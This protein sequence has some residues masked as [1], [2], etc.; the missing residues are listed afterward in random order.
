MAD[1]KSYEIH[2]TDRSKDPFLISPYTVDGPKHPTNNELDVNAVAAHTSLRLVGKGLPNYGERIFENLVNLLENFANPTEPYYPIEGQIWYDTSDTGVLK[3]YD[4]SS[5]VSLSQTIA[6]YNAPSNPTSGQLWYDSSTPQLMVWNGSNWVSTADRYLLKSGDLMSGTLDMDGNYI[7]NLP[8]LSATDPDHYAAPKGYVDAVASTV[9]G[10]TSDHIDNTSNVNS[11]SGSVTDALNTLNTSLLHLDGTDQMAGSLD[12]GSNRI[13]NMAEPTNAHDATTKQWVEDHV[14]TEIG[15]SEDK[16]LESAAIAD[17]DGDGYGT[18]TLTTTST[19]DPTITVDTEVALESHTHNAT[20]VTYQFT[21]E[22]LDV[23]INRL[24]TD[25]APITSPTFDGNA[26]IISSGTNLVVRNTPTSAD[27]AATKSYVDQAVSDGS[28]G[29]SGGLSL[30]DRNLE[31]STGTTSFTTPEYVVGTNRL[32]VFVNGQKYYASARGTLPILF[33]S[34]VVASNSSELEPDTQGYQTVVLDPSVFQTSENTGLTDDTTT[35][36]AD[37]S[38]NGNAVTVSVEGQNAQTYESLIT[39][40][41]NAVAGTPEITEITT[42]AD[43]SGS[44]NET[45][46]SLNAPSVEVYVWYNVD[47]TGTD[48]QPLGKDVGIEV[49]I[50][51]DDTADTV[52]Q[53]TENILNAADVFQATVNSNVVTITNIQGGPVTNASDGTLGT[54]FSF[55]ITQEGSGGAVASLTQLGNLQITS[56]IDG[57][58]STISINDTDLFSSLTQ[59]STINTAVAGT[60]TTYSADLTIDGSINETISFSGDDAQTFYDVMRQINNDLSASHAAIIGGDIYVVSNTYGTASSVSLDT[61]D[62]FLHLDGFDQI[63]TAKSGLDE[64]YEE[65]G[66]AGDTSTSIEFTS[67]IPTDSKVEF[68]VF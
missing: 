27:H 34:D 32:W 56:N 67:S 15:N 33:S 7:T 47:D 3:I 57:T 43:T 59:Y 63:G 23:A 53:Q 20:D 19:T 55:N 1:N 58:S 52:A 18:L 31:V 10:L 45:W 22:T 9:S 25:K 14:A 62:L 8:T 60:S 54:G 48:P 51:A 46:F 6:F 21:G 35:Y 4:G 24:D 36:T 12:M 2:Y 16:V 50:S 17:G 13:I 66:I 40:I 37:I 61:D 30:I 5:F 64:A 65:Q 11:S 29:S 41:N 28:T 42:V 68:L 39:E 26:V 38:V 44:L 49:G